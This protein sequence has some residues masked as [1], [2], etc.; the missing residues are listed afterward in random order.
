MNPTLHVVRRNSFFHFPSLRLEGDDLLDNADNI[1]A[2]RNPQGR[3]APEDQWYAHIVR[4]PDT[5]PNAI[6]LYGRCYYISIIAQALCNWV[7]AGV[8]DLDELNVI[9]DF[10]RYIVHENLCWD[11]NY[12]FPNYFYPTISRDRL[13]SGNLWG[14]LYQFPSDPYV[15]D[16]INDSETVETFAL[17]DMSGDV[18]VW[19]YLND[20]LVFEF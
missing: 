12:H 20:D 2:T 16:L 14:F 4:D 1:I 9:T 10:V 8:I 17:T 11:L 6:V 7:G 13:Q 18:S 5:T 3:I 19:E 15:I